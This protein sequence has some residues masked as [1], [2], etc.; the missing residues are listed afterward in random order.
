MASQRVVLDEG[1]GSMKGN[2]F[3]KELS[4]RVVLDEGYGSMKGNVFSKCF[5]QRSLKEGGP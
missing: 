4:K 3:P 5:P 2:V 1:Y